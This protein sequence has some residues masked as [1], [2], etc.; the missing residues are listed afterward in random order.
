LKKNIEPKKDKESIVL[1]T[2]GFDFIK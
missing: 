2:V 1:P